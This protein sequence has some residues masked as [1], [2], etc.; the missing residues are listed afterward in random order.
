MASL[1]VGICYRKE[2]LACTHTIRRIRLLLLHAPLGGKTQAWLD[3]AL[4]NPPWPT[5]P[6]VHSR[7]FGGGGG[8]TGWIGPITTPPGR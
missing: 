6:R 5:R 7:Q 8:R 1:I 2:Q 4:K 3:W